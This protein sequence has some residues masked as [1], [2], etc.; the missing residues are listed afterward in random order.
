METGMAVSQLARE[1][2]RLARVL[3]TLNKESLSL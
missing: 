3:H 1:T 2:Q